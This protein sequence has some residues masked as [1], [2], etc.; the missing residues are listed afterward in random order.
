MNE[1]ISNGACVCQSGYT[2]NSCGICSLS[3]TENTFLFMGRCAMCPVNMNYMPAIGGC[4]CPNGY[5]MDPISNTCAVSTFIVPSCQSGTYYDNNAQR[6]LNCSANC[7]ACTSNNSGCTAC[8]RGYN[9]N[10]GVCVAICGDGVVVGSETC[11]TGS[12]QQ[13]GCR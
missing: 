4:V 10:N 7:A 6:C 9:L 13:P 8:S 5:Y 11:D 2:R 3:C 1:V 12:N